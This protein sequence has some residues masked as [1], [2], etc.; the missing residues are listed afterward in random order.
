MD[1]LTQAELCLSRRDLVGAAHYFQQAEQPSSACNRLDAGLWQLHMLSGDFEQAWQASDRI[2]SRNTPDPNRL[3]NG[4]PIAGKNVIIRSLHGLGDAVQMFRYAPLLRPLA[5]SVTWQVPP[6]L[7]DLTKRFCGPDQVITW[8]EHSLW[9]IQIEIME[10]PYVFRT[11]LADLPIARGY[12]ALPSECKTRARPRAGVVWA[13]GEWKQSRSVPFNAFREIFTVS[14]IDFISL[15]GGP[16][17][18]AHPSLQ[19]I[20]PGLLSLAQAIANLDLVIT[21]DTLAAHL[22]GALDIPAYVL[23]EHAA[24]WRWMTISDSSPWYPSLRLFR[25]PAPGDWQT[26][27]ESIRKTIGT[28]YS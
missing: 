6:N 12:L 22:A 5:R 20:Q 18:E 25:Q 19:T 26:P 16:Q 4:E 17:K 8:E 7:L 14:S 3:W 13:A 27:I 28:L 9:E 1:L 21:V 10:L 15:Q 23:L 11:T 2:R 24:D